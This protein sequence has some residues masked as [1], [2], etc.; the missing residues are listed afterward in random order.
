MIL[1]ASYKNCFSSAV[2]VSGTWDKTKTEQTLLWTALV[3]SWVHI[4]LVVF[5]HVKFNI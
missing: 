3:V 4:Y 2:V 5:E 1:S